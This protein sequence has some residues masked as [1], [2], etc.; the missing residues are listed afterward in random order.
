MESTPGVKLAGMA[1]VT[2]RQL[3]PDKVSLGLTTKAEFP[4]NLQT[5]VVMRPYPITLTV[6]AAE[7]N[8]Y[9]SRSG[10]RGFLRAHPIVPNAEKSYVD[11]PSCCPLKS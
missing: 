8:E 5:T 7:F 6:L 10:T 3:F 2:P 11:N 4:L 1:H 9:E